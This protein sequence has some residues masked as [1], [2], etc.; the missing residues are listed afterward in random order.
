M[1]TETKTRTEVVEKEEKIIVCDYCRLITSEDIDD[2]QEFTKMLLEPKFT[3]GEGVKTHLEYYYCAIENAET[4]K[5]V[6]NVIKDIIGS[7]WDSHEDDAADLCPNC[8]EQL[9]GDEEP[10]GIRAGTGYIKKPK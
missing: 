3:I 2:D 9:F 1:A 6:K 4:K 5:D 10:S 8:A 7:C